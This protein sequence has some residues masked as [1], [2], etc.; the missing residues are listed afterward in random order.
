MVEMLV[1]SLSGDMR[2]VTSTMVRYGV[3]AKEVFKLIMDLLQ[4]TGMII[5]YFMIKVICCY[6]DT[7]PTG[8][9]WPRTLTSGN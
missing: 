2:T 7:F 3:A 4:G 6:S 5:Y 9:N 8:L 1:P